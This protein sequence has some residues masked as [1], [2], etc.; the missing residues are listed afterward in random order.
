MDIPVRRGRFKKCWYVEQRFDTP[1]PS[2]SIAIQAR[3]AETSSAGAVRPRIAWIQSFERPERPTQNS[4][5]HG[6][7]LI[8]STLR[9]FVSSVDTIPGPHD[10]GI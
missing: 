10:P 5:E 9:A 3:R 7:L 2:N 6:R 4:G 1:M 8:V